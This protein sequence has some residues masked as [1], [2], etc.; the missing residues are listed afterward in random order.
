[1]TEEAAALRVMKTVHDHAKSNDNRKAP[2]FSP[3]ESLLAEGPSELFDVQAIGGA[4]Y[5]VVTWTV[6]DPRRMVDLMRLGVDGII[7][8]RPDLLRAAVA[9]FDPG[10]I[11][12][13]GLVD[14]D[15][16]DIQ[17]HRGAR[18]LRPEN[19]L[20]AMEAGLDHS[21]TTLET[22]TGVTAD[23]VSVLSHDPYLTAGKCRRADGDRY[24]EADEV[25][26]KNLSVRELQS[27]FRCDGLV[28]GE[29]Q[30]N[31]LQLSPVS[32]AFSDAAALPHPYVTPTL[33]NLFDFVTFYADYYRS[34]GG[35]S[36]P[37]AEHRWKNAARVR[38]NI[39]TKLDPRGGRDDKGLVFAERTV[40]PRGFVDALAGT[41]SARG[42]H[43][44]ADI[45][46]FDFRTLL[47]THEQHPMIRTVFLFGAIPTTSGRGDGANF[48]D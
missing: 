27:E 37:D 5:P 45:Q 1:M 23:G 48:E 6:N 31:D 20:P 17:G 25:L 7:S 3:W 8:D 33:A 26:I 10:L 40:G 30:S 14:I 41:I 28:R 47:L 24:D 29:L 36:H 22:D 46:S 12:P 38:F 4:G 44:R 39:E 35:A 13:D 32:V 9:Q 2:V 42:L 21:V 11:G 18:D 16:M 43:D 19:T 15:R 34:G